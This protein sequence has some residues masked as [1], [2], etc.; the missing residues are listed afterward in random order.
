MRTTKPELLNRL[1]LSIALAIE[2]TGL[3]MLTVYLHSSYGTEY[4]RADS[5]L[6]LAFLSES[7]LAFDELMEEVPCLPWGIFDHWWYK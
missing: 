6:D 5:G 7:P 4:I 2:A 3:K 1:R